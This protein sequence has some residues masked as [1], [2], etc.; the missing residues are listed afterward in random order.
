MQLAQADPDNSVRAF[1]RMMGAKT[2]SSDPVRLPVPNASGGFIAPQEAAK[3]VL[4]S[5]IQA[6]QSEVR[7]LDSS[8][9]P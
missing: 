1:K 7:Q 2:E 6:A 9:K 8:L 4:A 5:L 3:L